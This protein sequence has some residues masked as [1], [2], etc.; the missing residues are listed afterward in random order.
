MNTW[1]LIFIFAMETPAVQI[2]FESQQLCE[3]ALV[4]MSKQLASK[5]SWGKTAG[6]CV[7][8]ATHD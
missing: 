4:Q 6:V 8:R 1:V 7:K 2:T 5:A 3:T